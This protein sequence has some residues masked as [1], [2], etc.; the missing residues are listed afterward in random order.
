[1][2]MKHI[3][4]RI[5]LDVVPERAPTRM[6][7]ILRFV[8]YP[9]WR[10]MSH[11]NIY[12]RRTTEKRQYLILCVHDRSSW[13]IRE[14]SLYSQET[15]PSYLPG[16]PMKIDDTE[17]AKIARAAMISIHPELNACKIAEWLKEGVVEITES[18]DTLGL[19]AC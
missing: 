19:F 18:N 15:K 4:R 5:G 7:Q 16:A 3:A 13:L 11:D 1:M 12:C 10:T 14:T 9:I 6:C 2:T 17:P 8:V